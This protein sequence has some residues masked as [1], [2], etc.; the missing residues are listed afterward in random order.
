MYS[1]TLFVGISPK[2]PL[3]GIGF[4]DAA[5]M[6]QEGGTMSAGENY[7]YPGRLEVFFTTSAECGHAPRVILPVCEADPEAGTV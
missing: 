3:F 4:A 6:K 1:K 2:L 7:P 5:S